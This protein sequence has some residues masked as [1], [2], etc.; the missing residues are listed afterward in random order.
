MDA[1]IP[2]QA[3]TSDSDLANWQAF[4]LAYYEPIR[5]ALQLLRVPGAEVDELANAFIL[6]AAEKNFLDAFRAFQ[7]REQQA[8]RRPSFGRIST[9]RSRITS[10]T[11]TARSHPVA[12]TGP[13]PEVAEA[14]VAD[15][16]QDLDPDALYALDIL[17]QALQACAGTANAPASRTSG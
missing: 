14:L 11:P 16:V 5:R 12:R 17:H 6:K 13:V 8:G 10:S 9:G 1:P 2:D 7:R 15:A 3:M 4:S